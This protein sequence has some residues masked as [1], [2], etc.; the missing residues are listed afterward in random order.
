[1]T[2]SPYT[3]TFTLFC[4]ADGTYIAERDGQTYAGPTPLAAVGGLL[5][6]LDILTRTEARNGR[7]VQTATPLMSIS[8]A[9]LGGSR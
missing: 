2:G 4:G 7:M 1:M 5:L 8:A 9:E 6:Q 3:F